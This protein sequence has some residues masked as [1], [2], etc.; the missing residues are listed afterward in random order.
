MT[1]KLTKKKASASI[2]PPSPETLTPPAKP[3]EK[4]VVK[5]PV[6]K[7]APAIKTTSAPKKVETSVTKAPAVIVK[8]QMQKVT[9]EAM[10]SFDAGA[11]LPINMRIHT[12]VVNPVP[13]TVNAIG[14][15][16]SILDLV[17]MMKK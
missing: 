8:K 17:N 5:K 13:S 16:R 9:E 1:T 3:V 6:A 11:T 4:V 2:S 10:R 15:H 12:P 7:K 14:G